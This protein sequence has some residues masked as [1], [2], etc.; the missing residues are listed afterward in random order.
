MIIGIPK[1]IKENEYRVGM[2]PEGV[3]VLTQ[4][5]HQVVVEKDAGA[6]S[7]ITN[8]EYERANAII[9][10]SKEEVFQRAQII[11]KVKEPLLSEYP[12]LQRGQMIFAYFHLAADPPLTERLLASD[13]TAIA[14][15]TVVDEKGLL[16]LLIPMSAIAGRLAVLNGSH[17]LQRPFGG[18]GILLGGLT[19]VPPGRVVILG[20][21]TVGTH[22]AQVAVGLGADVVILDNNSAHLAAIGKKMDGL[23]KT[24]IALPDT[25]AHHLSCA[26]LVVG[27]VL[28]AGA[29]APLLVR[30]PL[31]SQMKRGAVIADVA[32]DQGGCCETSRPTTHVNP[33]YEVDGV[34]HYC[35]PNIPAAVPRTATYVLTNVT[36]PYILN[37][38]RLGLHE[39]LRADPLLQGGLNVHQGN[40]KHPAVAEVYGGQAKTML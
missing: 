28:T 23:C 20:A 7:A 12:L 15:E 3:M 22:A 38:V 30:R 39:A 16:P 34:L 40:I 6:G 33:V 13:V 14:Y 26:D 2:T 25:I 11:L 24:D 37:I 4:A 8:T 1:E 31:L 9:L 27:A 32:I 21:G 19:G 29:R 10:S 36:L 17:A 35:V 18:R 5:G